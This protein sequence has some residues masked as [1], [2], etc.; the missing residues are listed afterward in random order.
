KPQNI[1]YT[2]QGQYV[3][4]DFGIAKQGAATITSARALSPDYAPAEQVRGAPTDARSDLYSLGATAYHLLTG[5]LPANVSARLSNGAQLI[6]P[7]DL[8]PGVPP[9]LERVLL[10]MLELDPDA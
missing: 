2:P 10:Q 7:S 8:V 9:P 1:K 5:R 4:L 6:P 3:L